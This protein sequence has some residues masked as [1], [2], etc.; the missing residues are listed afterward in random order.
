[1]GTKAIVDADSMIYAA[2]L[3]CDNIEDA[4][5]YFLSIL[6]TNID[7]LS[8]FCELDEVIICNGSIN[9]FRKD[10]N[11]EYKLNRTGEPPKLLFELHDMVKQ[12]ENS[13][14]AD[15][16][17]TDDVVA[18]LWS[19]NPNYIIV[20]SDKDYKQLPCLFFDSYY[21]RMYLTDISFYESNYNF[22]EQMIIGDSADNVNY[23]KGYGKS[24][25]K[26]NFVGIETR[27]GFMKKV[28]YIYK[29]IHGELAKDK[30][31]ECY[32][33]LRLRTDVEEINIGK[34]D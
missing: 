6:N 12:L 17:E 31:R 32:N 22:F 24:W 11:T 29:E 13:Y 5:E 20:A 2:S 28:L 16:Y 3:K 23:C 9:N 19:E 26:K 1:M 15:G 34:L 18:T 14:W 7:T 8:E 10:L 25:V 27:F 30:F 33:L 21:K 4:Y